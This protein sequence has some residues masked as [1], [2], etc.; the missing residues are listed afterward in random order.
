MMVGRR[1]RTSSWTCS[2]SAAEAKRKNE[3][4]TASPM[5][6]LGNRSRRAS[7]SKRSRAREAA[8]NRGRAARTIAQPG[9]DLVDLRHRGRI[10]FVHPVDLARGEQH[11]YSRQPRLRRLLLR[12]GFCPAHLSRRADLQQLRG[13]GHHLLWRY[14]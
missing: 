9:A 4:A 12:A 10:I 1:W 3:K 2:S 14:L 7:R 13:I 6:A 11:A 5:V 8:D